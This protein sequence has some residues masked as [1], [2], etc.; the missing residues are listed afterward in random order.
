M[1][2]QIF[3]QWIKPLKLSAFDSNTGTLL[4][5]LPSE[6]AA[7]WVR[8]RYAERLLLAW[9]T[10]CPEVRNLALQAQSGAAKI[11]QASPL[12]GA[13]AV[14]T[15]SQHNIAPESKFRLD[16]DPRMT[17]DQFV[18]GHSNVLA[19]NAA[20]RTAAAE[21]PLFC[22]LYLQSSTGQGKS[23]L[24]HAIGHAFREEFPASTIIYMSAERFMI[25]FVSAMRRNEGME[26]KASLREADLLMIDDIQF[27]VGKNSTQEEFLHTVDSLISQGKRVVVAADRPPQALDGVD[28]RLLS[29]LSMGLVADIQSAGL[30][31]RRDILK[32]R[33]ATM[34]HQQVSEE[35]VEFLART[36]SRNLRELEGGLNKLLAYAQLTGREISRE[37]AEEQLS[38]ILSACRR[39][40]TIDEI[41][42]TVCEYYRLDRNEMSSKRRARAVARPRQVAM[43]LAKVMTPRS[44][45]EIGRKF[46][47][48]DH[49]TVIHA[50][51]LVEQL[52]GEDS[53]MDNDV[54]MLLRQLES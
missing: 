6:F 11:A 2:A 35:V 40:I 19:L 9:K 4:L 20:Q 31:L 42:R 27:I 21:K 18:A 15:P 43:Y 26:F 44:Y 28:Q 39:R 53:E 37:L 48:R 51:K 23:H 29:R 17:F 32:H 30:E 54:R 10:H 45:P 8:D 24:M 52:R 1:G 33:L 38:D 25:E 7:N 34:P 50:V 3:G 13:N 36:I 22:P 46:G 5:I 49:S 12:N 41:Q 16:L 14:V 47:G